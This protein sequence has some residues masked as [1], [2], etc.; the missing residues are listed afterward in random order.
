[1]INERAKADCVFMTIC[2]VRP[3]VEFD[4]IFSGQKNSG[5]WVVS[6]LRMKEQ[7]T[8]LTLNRLQIRVADF[9]H[10]NFIGMAEVAWTDACLFNA[11][12]QLA[13]NVH[14]S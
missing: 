13:W 12:A 4:H 11:N 5:E 10:N 6:G 3:P 14:G 2:Y 8:D 9:S 1:M 7:D